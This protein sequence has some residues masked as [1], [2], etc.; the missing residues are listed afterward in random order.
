MDLFT[1]PTIKFYTLI[2]FEMR[3]QKSGQEDETHT[4]LLFCILCFLIESYY[5]YFL[6]TKEFIK[7]LLLFMIKLYKSTK[8]QIA[9][10]SIQ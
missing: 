9:I 6:N 8:M 7:L 10:C 4:R 3:K 1:S 5:K 2:Q